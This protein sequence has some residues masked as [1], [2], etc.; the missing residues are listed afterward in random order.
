MVGT[1]TGRSDPI[2]GL[3]RALDHSNI[4]PGSSMACG[5]IAAAMTP[6]I[7]ANAIV[8]ALSAGAA[9]GATDTAKSAI[10]DAYQGLKSLVKKKFGHDSEAAQAI[11]KVEAKPDSDGRKKTLAEELE[12]VNS[13]SDAELISAAQSLLALIK[14]LPQ[15]EKHIQYAQGTGIAQADGGSTATVIMHGT[16]R[17]DD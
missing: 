15:G 14:A 8:A 7:V 12:A 10:A 1:S 11:E 5:T 13:T 4:S 6:D 2:S 3:L 17:K 9:A 16:L